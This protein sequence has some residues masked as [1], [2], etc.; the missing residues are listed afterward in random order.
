VQAPE[1]ADALQIG[2]APLFDSN[3]DQIIALAARNGVPTVCPWPEFTA[4]GGLTN[5]G[6]SILNMLRQVGNYTGQILNGATPADLPVQRP[7]KLAFDIN[8]KTA[9]ALG[10][11][12]PRAL[13]A[14]QRR[15]RIRFLTSAVGT[16]RKKMPRSLESDSA[17]LVDVHRPAAHIQVWPISDM[18]PPD[19]RRSNQASDPDENIVPRCDASG[20]AT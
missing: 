8:L 9:K 16:F 10:L 6:T 13:L 12:I 11:D 1:H 7:T 20:S 17:P 3:S 14:R 15:Y 18:A 19:T 2:V 5:Y 4:R